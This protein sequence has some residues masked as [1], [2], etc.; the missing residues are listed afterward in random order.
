VA[1]LFSVAAY[2][3]PDGGATVRLLLAMWAIWQGAVLWRPEAAA[4]GLTPG[5]SSP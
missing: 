2:T 1:G 3:T 4:D 5:G